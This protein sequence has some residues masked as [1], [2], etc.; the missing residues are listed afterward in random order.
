MYGEYFDG[1][2]DCSYDS[3]DYYDTDDLEA[4]AQRESW[5]DAVAERESAYTEAGYVEDDDFGSDGND[6]EMYEDDWHYDDGE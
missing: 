4:F 3:T 2:E 6:D 5:E 1:Y